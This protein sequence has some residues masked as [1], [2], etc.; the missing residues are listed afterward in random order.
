V[1]LAARNNDGVVSRSVEVKT[2][3]DYLLNRTY[4]DRADRSSLFF[5]RW[6]RNLDRGSWG[7]RSDKLPDNTAIGGQW[8]MD[9]TDRGFV[10]T[11]RMDLNPAMLIKLE[12]NR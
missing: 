2:Y 7:F 6:R 5:T 12:Y 10:L 9:K 4:N 1:V 8:Q 3:R 11:T